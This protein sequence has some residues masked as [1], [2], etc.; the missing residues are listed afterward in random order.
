MNYYISQKEGHFF[1]YT[2]N[3]AGKIIDFIPLLDK[4]EAMAGDIYCG[5]VKDI[6]KGLN[7]AFIDIGVANQVAFLPLDDC[8]EPIKHGQMVLV[9][10]VK[11]AIGQKGP[12]VT[13]AYSLPG[14]YSVYLQ[15]SQKIYYSSK[16]SDLSKERARHWLREARLKK[17]GIIIRTNFEHSN[18]Q[19]FLSEVD[20]LRQQ[21]DEINRRFIYR[22]ETGRL[23]AGQ[24]QWGHVLKDFPEQDIDCLT[25]NNKEVFEA[26]KAFADRHQLA[27][28]DRIVYSL[29]DYYLIHDLPKILKEATARKVWLPSG[30][31]L[32]IEKTEAFFVIDVNTAKFD[33]KKNLQATIVKTN[34]EAI[35]EIARQLRLR[36]MAGIILVDLIDMSDVT[37]R[38]MI[39]EELEALVRHDLVKVKLHGITKLGILEITRQRKRKSLYDYKTESGNLFET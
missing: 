10:V 35:R 4:A 39:I 16:L 30:G 24:Q 25:I 27:Y 23:Y 5:R 14:Y 33:G 34:Q 26:V 37:N 38:Q 21:S 19:A 32:I 6:K 2:I 11:E 18:K 31:N 28:A 36:N 17:D 29:D 20:R 8:T 12:R 7:A 13:M 22:K 1:V 3:Q 9:Q 15:D